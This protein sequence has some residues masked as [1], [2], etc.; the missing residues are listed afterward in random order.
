MAS[1]AAV[2]LVEV[3]L[4]PIQRLVVQVVKASSSSPTLQHRQIM[5]TSTDLVIFLQL[6][7]WL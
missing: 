5:P 6:A 3:T 1:T 4:E 7:H 2:G